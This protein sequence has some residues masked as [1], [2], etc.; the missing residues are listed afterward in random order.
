MRVNDDALLGDLRL[1]VCLGRAGL[2]DG[3]G[4]EGPGLGAEDPRPLVGT[5][6]LPGHVDGLA[7]R[8]AAAVELVEKN[9]RELLKI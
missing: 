5:L 3:G 9:R 2:V 6:L 7:Q 8:V 1:L 4:C